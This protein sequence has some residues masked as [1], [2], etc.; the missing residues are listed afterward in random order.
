MRLAAGIAG[1][2]GLALA[3]GGTAIAMPDAPG[4]KNGP[5]PTARADLIDDS[6]KSVVM[7]RTY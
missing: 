5:T 6:G 4:T 2:A 3:A 7:L 1:V